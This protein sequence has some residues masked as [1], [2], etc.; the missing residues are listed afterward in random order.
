MVKVQEKKAQK[1]TPKQERFCREYILDFNATEAARRAGYSPK[2]A[3]EQ[4]SQLLRITKV[5]EFIKSLQ[6]TLNTKIE[7]KYSLSREKVL[8]QYYRLAFSDIR[9]LYDDLG[10]MKNIKD[11]DYDTAASIASLESQE[12]NVG[13]EQVG[14]IKKL[15]IVDKKTALDSISK[16]MG[17]N[18]I[19]RK[20]ITGADGKPLEINVASSV[21]YSK[22]SEN[23]LNEILNAIK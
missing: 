5:S 7:S 22:L 20:E 8:D 15:K 6:D 11:L 18:A 1:L 17:Y 10:R 9:D 23:A 4:G 3:N 16:V 19:E 13:M 12:L 14:T 21:D 2:T